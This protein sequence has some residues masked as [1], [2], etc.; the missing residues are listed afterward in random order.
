MA[1]RA[2]LAVVLVL[3]AALAGCSFTTA[4]RFTECTT[5]VDCGSDA[6]CV[7]GYCLA[8][9]AGCRRQEAGGTVRAFEKGDRVP[10]A[11]LLPITDSAG[12]TDDSEVQS[13][14]AI[15]LA[16]AEVNDRT[17]LR[18]RP[19]GVF[20]CD[21][22]RD[23]DLTRA[24]AAWVV[25]NLQAPAI[26]SSGSGQAK[27]IAQEPS[28]LDAGTLVIS[29]SATSPSLASVFANEG[30]VWR[31]AP[32]DSL[33]ARVLVRLLRADFPDAG[34][35]RIDVVY[36][37]TDYGAGLANNVADGLLDAGYTSDRRPYT[38]GDTASLTTVVN[39]LAND[40]PRATVLVGYPEDVK[41][42]V[43]RARTFPALSRAGGHRWYL[44]DA[45][46]DPA[47]LS[48]EDG[49]AAV[50]RTELDQMVGTAP[51]QGAGGAFAAF[52]SSF[53]TRYGIDP[54]SFSYTS[55][56]YDAMWLVMLSA[57]A[58]QSLGGLTGPN[59]G[60]GMTRL[61]ATSQQPVLL[62]ADGWT[63]PSNNLLQGLS[64]NVE[65]ASGPLDF[66]PDAGVPNAPYE[67]WQVTDGGIRVVRL[68]NP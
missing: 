44:T 42:L 61:S 2:L 57:A 62:R 54:N 68:V 59:F 12:V 29:T 63:E 51:A 47:V 60:V 3:A 15:R 49:G 50:T 1:P 26:I 48:L 20:Y 64:V 17:G 43:A 53:R 7:Q 10:I 35:T 27:T 37:D 4:G 5:D 46:K 11:A 23:P 65:G 58:A 33:Q 8:L 66:D 40:Q 21:T 56:S 24:Q 14:N 18:G 6:A 38:R 13:L 32:P 28:R 45:M 52:R 41:S 9:P 30:N 31:V 36:E 25:G 16:A 39:G 34:S 19:F 55:H 22:R 67:L